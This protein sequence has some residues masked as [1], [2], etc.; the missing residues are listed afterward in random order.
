MCDSAVIT[1]SGVIAS[2]GAKMAGG[3][4]SMNVQVFWTFPMKIEKF[5]HDEGIIMSILQLR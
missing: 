1:F 2:G 5:S 3:K 4:T